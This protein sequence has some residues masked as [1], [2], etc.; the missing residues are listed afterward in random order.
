MNRSPKLI[1]TVEIT[2]GRMW[3][4]GTPSLLMGNY[5][6]AIDTSCLRLLAEDNRHR[7]HVIVDIY[8]GF[9]G[10][11]NVH[12]FAHGFELDDKP[13]FRQTTIAE[14]LAIGTNNKE[15]GLPSKGFVYALGSAHVDP[16][17]RIA[18]GMVDPMVF[19]PGLESMDG[20]RQML[21]R[22]IES[23]WFKDTQVALVR[24]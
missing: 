6:G 13:R 24:L 21:N 5:G 16:K 7:G 1:A 8:N 18:C 12:K 3:G 10:T 11:F 23:P 20:D 15:L 19:Y 17:Q 22:A 9:D 2:P 14:L 4:A